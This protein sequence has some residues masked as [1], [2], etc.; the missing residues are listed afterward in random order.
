M[1]RV[2]EKWLIHFFLLITLFHLETTVQDGM[3]APNWDFFFK[4]NKIKKYF[5]S[6]SSYAGVSMSACA[7]FVHEYCKGM[8]CGE[9]SREW[10][11]SGKCFCT[12]CLIFI[13]TAACTGRDCCCLQ[14]TEEITGLLVT[15]VMCT[16][17]KLGTW[18]LECKYFSIT[19]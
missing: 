12:K 3:K 6:K 4:K 18:N 2:S 5:A 9:R 15:E 17:H 19:P 1:F 8:T 7:E 13:F 10:I 14:L 16:T 11:V